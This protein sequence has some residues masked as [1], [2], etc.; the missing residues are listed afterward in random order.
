METLNNAQL[1]L[2]K[3]FKCGLSEQEYRELKQI[4]SEYLA[5]KL[6]AEVDKI[7]EEKGYTAEIIEGWKDEHFRTPY[8]K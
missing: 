6:I 5:K 8:L 4:L 3:L 7:A 2:L 1:E